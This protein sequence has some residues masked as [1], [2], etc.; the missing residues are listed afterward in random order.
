MNMPQD[1]NK[2]S[3]PIIPPSI[4]VKATAVHA[5]ECTKRQASRSSDLHRY[6]F[7]HGLFPFDP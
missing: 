4:T 5:A 6:P 3:L 7:N 2:S 1:K